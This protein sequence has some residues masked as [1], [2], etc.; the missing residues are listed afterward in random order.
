M[1]PASPAPQDLAPCPFCGGPAQICQVSAFFI[2]EC[3]NAECDVN[4]DVTHVLKHVAIE[5]WNRR[6]SSTSTSQAAAPV[7]VIVANDQVHGWHMKALKPWNEIGEGTL[8]YAEPGDVL[9]SA[10]WI[11]LKHEKPRDW[12]QVLVALDNGSVTM[13]MRGS[14]GWHWD[15]GD[16]SPDSDATATHWQPWPEALNRAAI[17]A[18]TAQEVK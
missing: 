15:D 12:Q 3:D 9:D 18:S 6:G 2:V 4:P 5:R 13:G 1:T 10:R 16:D 11:D 17:A 7:G 14:M 8:L